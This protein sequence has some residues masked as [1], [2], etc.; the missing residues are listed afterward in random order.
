MANKNIARILI[1]HMVMCL[2]CLIIFKLTLMGPEGG[3]LAQNLS[4]SGNMIVFAVIAVFQVL[5]I[6]IYFYIGIKVCSFTISSIMGIMSIS[7]I[8]IIFIFIL[9]LLEN[10]IESAVKLFSVWGN[11]PFFFLSVLTGYN[12]VSNAI[13]IFLPTIIMFIGN[14]CGHVFAQKR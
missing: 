6:A 9:I 10:N 3:I 2:V 7:I 11:T 5:V 13:F 12:I 14:I 8:N 1:I 4:P